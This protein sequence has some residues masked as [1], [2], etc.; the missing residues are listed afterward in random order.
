MI[1]Y[2]FQIYGPIYANSYGLMICLGILIFT[3]LINQDPRRKNLITSDKLQNL[4]LLSTLVGIIGGRALWAL[5]NWPMPAYDLLAVWE[6]GLSVLGAIIAIL[7]FL[8]IYLKNKHIPVLPLLDL[9]AI[10]APLLQAISR[11]G[12]FLA[13]CCYGLPT[14]FS[15]GVIYTHPDTA[16]PNNLKN[17]AL[18]P[19]QL[20]SALILFVIFLLMHNLISKY[21]KQPGQLIAIYL[22][23][24]SL[25]RFLVDFVRADQEFCQNPAL[26]ALALHQW[27]CLGIFS[28]ALGLFIYQSKQVKI[29][30]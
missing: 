15:W 13:G 16:V 21:F 1:P 7:L 23:L 28:Y 6:G 25:E 12:C 18:H 19:A 29:H 14:N 11:L 22:M 4:I 30:N 27:I 5:S 9:V 8:P 17:I 3:Y 20:Y 24:S 26:K 2:L 10:Y